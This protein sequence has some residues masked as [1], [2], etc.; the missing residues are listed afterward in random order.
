MKLAIDTETTGSHFR[1][2]DAPYYISTCDSEGY[3]KCW[4]F[5]VDPYTRAVHIPR[6]KLKEVTEYFHRYDTFVFHNAKF[7]LAALEAIEIDLRSYP[8]IDTIHLAHLIDNRQSRKLKDLSTLYLDCDGQDWSADDETELLQAINQARRFIRKSHTTKALSKLHRWLITP[9]EEAEDGEDGEH[10]MKVDAWVPGQLALIPEVWDELPRET[11]LGWT[12]C[13]EKYGTRDA[14][15]TM[16][17]CILLK[18]YLEEHESQ[19]NPDW[20]FALNL[21]SEALPAFMEM[22]RY[23]VSIIPSALREATAHHEQ[24]A[25]RVEGEIQS[26]TGVPD[27]NPRSPTQLSGLLFDHFKLPT[28]TITKSGQP[29]TNEDTLIRLI[30]LPGVKPRATKALKKILAY[31]KNDMM[32]RYLSTYQ[33]FRVG[34][35][36]HSSFNQVG[37]DT[38]RSS[39]SKPNMQN[40]GKGKEYDD[41]KVEIL[42]EVTEDD[43][44]LRRV[45]GP[46][47]GRIWLD[48]DYDQLQLRIFAYLSQDPKLIKAFEEGWDAHDFMASQIFGTETPSKLQ[49]RIAKNVNFGFV[50]GAGEK[51]IAAVSGD[52]TIWPMVNRL[53]PDAV[54]YMEATIREVRSTGKVIIRGYPLNVPRDQE[55]KI[56]AYT[57]VVYK[58]Q[59]MEGLIVKRAMKLCRDYLEYIRQS[60]PL[61]PREKLPFAFLSLLVHDELIFDFR[62]P[63]CIE[64]LQEHATQLRLCMERAGTDLGVVTP[65]SCS[66]VKES[67]DQGDEVQW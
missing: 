15:R 16:A 1:L 48:Y 46:Q 18:R 42:G 2:G 5:H 4:R 60:H 49:R 24:K 32:I 53:F 34:S 63:K 26:D 6:A 47:P 9:G 31:R 56:K 10:W 59:G 11:L 66:I 38:T 57:G 13:L 43:Y 20:K 25:I 55:G 64:D 8:I 21:Q 51:K 65:A 7:D 19:S 36:L 27:F 45:F 54:K 40:V 17:L 12:G 39:S 37:T 14:Q 33:D 44:L 30:Q 62:R 52:P 35:R 61:S 29:S 23:G 67:W 28:Q 58:V 22:E 3:L 50:F 41:A